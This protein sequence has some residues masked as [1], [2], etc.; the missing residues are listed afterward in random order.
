MTNKSVSPSM[1][2]AAA[3][4]FW[5]LDE[6]LFED[7]C[8]ELMQVE[9]NITEAEVYGTR[10]Q[11][12]YGIDIEAHRNDGC[13]E[14][15]QCKCYEKFSHRMIRKAAIDF[16]K[17]WQKKW[18]TENVTRFILIVACELQT[19]QHRN[20]ISKWKKKYT[21]IGV[22]F[23][24]WSNRII[25]SKLRPY[26]GVV[27]TYLG[28][29]TSWVEKICGQSMPDHVS[30][31]SPSGNISAMLDSQYEAFTNVANKLVKKNLDMVNE[32]AIAG[33]LQSA[34]AQLAKVKGDNA[35][36]G[37]IDDKTKAKVLRT[38]AFLKINFDDGIGEA[39]ILMGEAAKL[40]QTEGP[41]QIL[42][43][44]TWL[45]KGAQAALTE[46]GDAS[47]PEDRLFRAG[48]MVDLGQYDEAEKSLRGLKL[49][50]VD[51]ANL[52][53]IRSLIKLANGDLFKAYKC[54]KK[55]NEIAPTSY[56]VKYILG[57][58]EFFK[59]VSP[60]L[61]PKAILAYPNPIDWFYVK[62]DN[63][64]RE[65][66]EIAKSIFSGLHN[67][68][69]LTD[70]QKN[71]NEC[72][73]L[74]CLSCDPKKSAEAEDYCRSL[75]IDN[76][77]HFH[78]IAW[79]VSRGFLTDREI[80]VSQKEL[81]DI[82]DIDPTVEAVLSRCILH[83][84]FDTK[85][86]AA[87]LLRENYDLFNEQQLEELWNFWLVQVGASETLAL[88]SE[89][90]EDSSP[91]RADL[92]HYE[93]ESAEDGDYTRI[94][95]QGELSLK[96][97]LPLV[98]LGDV[99]QFL[100][101]SNEWQFLA[102]NSKAI[103][104]K[105]G[106]TDAVEMMAFACHSVGNHQQVLAI[107]ED[108]E[109]AF[110]N[111]KIPLRLKRVQLR[112]QRAMG[113]LPTAAQDAM[114]LAK[115][116]GD[117]A[118]YLWS[119]DV[120]FQK[121]DVAGAVSVLEE[122]RQQDKLSAD[123]AMHFSAILSA[124]NPDYAK[125]LFKD[126]LK[127]DLSVEQKAKAYLLSRKVGMSAEC[128]KLSST[129]YESAQRGE[130]DG[131]KALNSVEELNS[132][133]ENQQQAISHMEN[134]YA[135]GFGPIHFMLGAIGANLAQCYHQMRNRV[136][137]DGNLL[138]A[139]SLLI[140]HGGR[141][142]FDA[143]DSTADNL[144]L[145]LDVTALLLAVHL[146]ILPEVE[147]C[148]GVLMIPQELPASLLSM[149]NDLSPTEPE[150]YD[151]S[152]NVIFLA[153][154]GS[155]NILK[156]SQLAPVGNDIGE[157][158]LE[159][160][161]GDNTKEGQTNTLGLRDILSSLVLEGKISKSG[162]ND[163]LKKLG[164][165]SDFDLN[166]GVGMGVTLNCI[167]GVVLSL[168]KM[169][170][171]D[172]VASNFN[173][174]MSDA[175]YLS[176]KSY[177]DGANED[178]ALGEWVH[179]ITERVNRKIESGT[180]RPIAVSAYS[181]HINNSIE[182]G[183]YDVAALEELVSYSFPDSSFLWCDDR[184]INS[185]QRMNDAVTV[186]CLDALGAL[187]H[188]SAISEEK[189]YASIL[190]M[191][192][193]NFRYIP[194]LSD[195]LVF[196]IK[197]AQIKEGRLV[198]TPELRIL[199]KYLNAC[200]HDSEDFQS[201]NQPK[202]APNPHGEVG[203]FVQHNRGIQTSV[204]EIWGEEESSIE[205]KQLR[206][207]WIMDNLHVESFFVMPE[208]INDEEEKE[209][210]FAALMYSGFIGQ[211]ISLCSVKRGGEQTLCKEFLEWLYHYILKQRV[212]TNSGLLDEISHYTAKLAYKEDYLSK[213]HDY[214]KFIEAFPEDEG[215]EEKIPKLIHL[216]QW[217]N[218]QSLPATLKNKIK[219]IEHVK[220][221]FSAY[222]T[223]YLSIG[224]YVFNVLD[225]AKVVNA[226]AGKSLAL[227]TLNGERLFDVSTDLS[228]DSGKLYLVF[229]SEGERF[230]TTSA[231]NCALY[232]DIEQVS[233]SLKKFRYELDVPA[234]G[235]EDFIKGVV[236]ESS[237]YDSTMVVL[238]ALKDSCTIQY[239]QLHDQIGKEK[240][241]RVPDLLPF[242][243]DSLLRF[244]RI[245]QSSHSALDLS[246][247][248]Q[249]I[250]DEHGI[251]EALYRMGGLP[252]PM[253]VSILSALE[254]LDD[255]EREKV[256]IDFGEQPCSFFSNS[257]F[258]HLACKYKLDVEPELSVNFEKWVLGEN[259]EEM[260]EIQLAVYKWVFSEVGSYQDL[261]ACRPE[262]RMA[263]A[264]SHTSQ[265][266]NILFDSGIPSSGFND[267]V[268]SQ[269]RRLGIKDYMFSAHSGGDVNDPN[270]LS[271]ESFT[272]STL[273]YALEHCGE[274]F[275]TD[276]V[277]RWVNERY[278][279]S[280]SDIPFPVPNVFK[281]TH[282][283][284]NLLESFL[285][286]GHDVAFERLKQ[287]ELSEHSRSE[288]LKVTYVNVLDNLKGGKV[289]SNWAALSAITSY[290]VMYDDLYDRY[291]E[292][293]L[294]I[295]YEEISNAD[296]QLV[297]IGL[298]HSVF[299]ATTRKD[300]ETVKALCENLKK[301]VSCYAD[302]ETGSE[303]LTFE[304]YAGLVLEVAWKIALSED[305]IDNFANCLWRFSLALVEIDER[306]LSWARGPLAIIN[307]EL[308][309]DVA[310]N[311]S[312]VHFQLRA[313]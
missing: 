223:S 5:E 84:R 148:F 202:N 250:I 53:R 188:Y 67:D 142:V 281:D 153:G 310:R 306:L 210:S 266:C 6:A 211:S 231:A 277:R 108:N 83:M 174:N 270:F 89:S 92:L 41:S 214:V 264:W 119:A 91:T 209:F 293:V 301:I 144:N 256:I 12:Q 255:E 240:V 22:Q 137:K 262:V 159:H 126:A 238:D 206:S 284:T 175:E 178:L 54:I 279:V 227:K 23:E 197:K 313:M 265:I 170:L 276:R 9:P 151:A 162:C 165:E 298:A 103:V 189:Y 134:V 184:F 66:L 141:L 236:N 35:T 42:A 243:A 278:C 29:T 187:R 158:Y 81:D 86:D 312:K 127:C 234:D 219:R 249:R 43:R 15:G 49:D 163:A 80:G 192:E 280:N 44:I 198:E 79:A 76:P 27:S 21:K 132:F 10:G 28:H 191:R 58:L 31:T 260:L 173:V 201:V 288:H 71:Q 257:H 157:F 156:D 239:E 129:F 169:G 196:H 195:E 246:R 296:L 30:T 297:L 224:E 4:K 113:H 147:D 268:K 212:D 64:S 19:T 70:E 181:E 179:S 285:G 272:I 230:V 245:D 7:L 99:C 34:I 24:V 140:R 90:S 93:Q 287:K 50:G 203:F 218:L 274:G 61:T 39:N 194:L 233:E 136:A 87:I 115:Q 176:V 104:D 139:P 259:F 105:L 226:E 130:V 121:G 150:A 182:N 251:G 308:P 269:S 232:D 25:Q 290:G 248:A 74:A 300:F 47:T 291:M 309:I 305:D 303:T 102:D 143:Y 286:D 282:L 283:A 220:R 242:S 124:H 252:C 146:D 307:R 94:I 45:E 46:F 40:Y 101:Q 289:H 208:K 294:S 38:E 263:V 168:A 88:P 75:L 152:K 109:E 299:I 1:N 207:N 3:P 154:N 172:I 205:E 267:A 11:A 183:H 275:V 254:L 193:G 125:E 56:I 237:R 271:L 82:L 114:I 190:K 247:C 258:I 63:A 117:L 311:I 16:I 133:I 57:V 69:E 26:P 228:R 161:K 180:Y 20:E 37:V 48:I 52:W 97:E 122:L 73:R 221:K 229:S 72:W 17:H 14:V 225:L 110:P 13:L 68:C 166:D 78:A 123:G 36:W 213:E 128:A 100:A 216:L 59:A 77:T 164:V 292:W 55:A 171:L 149:K 235:F 177:V 33:K 98:V 111:R 160:K 244:L 253:P 32:L 112:A 116:T 155:I 217:E 85:N 215:A 185:Y 51:G 302:N 60:A 186:S 96:G 304:H 8:C 95:R 273:G 18:K 65:S 167:D 135:A 241:I 222:E 295:D 2:I 145:Y 131:V 200:L 107:L 138:S 62:K 106:T 199:R 118:D 120:F 261:Q 204:I